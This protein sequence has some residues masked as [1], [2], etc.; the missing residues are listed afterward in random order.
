MLNDHYYYLKG[1]IESELAE[2][3]F[4][5]GATEK[6]KESIRQACILRIVSEGLD[7]LQ[8]LE[9]YVTVTD[10]AAAKLLTTLEIDLDEKIQYIFKNIKISEKTL[11]TLHDS[12][13]LV[14]SKSQAMGEIDSDLGFVGFGEEEPFA[15]VIRLKCRG[16]YGGTL[17][18]IIAGS[19]VVSPERDSG[20]LISYFAQYDAMWGFVNGARP[21]F[22]NEFKRRVAHK[23]EDNWGSTTPEPIGW[24]LANEV[25][26]EMD[27]W[28]QSRYIDP[29]LN[30]ID[31]MGLKGLA[32]L[33]DSLVSLQALA[34]NGDRGPATVGG[35]IE[36]A[37]IDRINGVQWVRKLA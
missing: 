17:Q 6:K 27:E 26:Q 3:E 24:Q 13:P 30:T 15:K 34:A 7:H 31:G 12:A 37:T 8:K 11:Q 22:M 29:V 19:N 1:R 2:L 10:K 25:E 20:A 36:V 16:I 35:L 23:V 14:L 9:N 4:D 33:A 18:A 5:E 32:E 21:E 28:A